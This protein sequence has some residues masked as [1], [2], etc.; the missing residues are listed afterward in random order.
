MYALE[1]PLRWLSASA[2]KK[3]P[4]KPYKIYGRRLRDIPC[5]PDHI[6]SN[7]EGWRL[8]Y[9]AR[10]DPR[11][12]WDEDIAPRMDPGYRPE[13]PSK[14]Q[15]ARN[16]F[17]KNCRMLGWVSRGGNHKAIRAD[18]LN[19]LHSRNISFKNN[20]T[21]GLSWGVVD[22][23]AGEGGGRIA[24]KDSLMQPWS[25]EDPPTCISKNKVFPPP[26]V[27]EVLYLAQPITNFTPMSRHAGCDGRDAES[28]SAGRKRKAPDDAEDL[29]EN[30]DQQEVDLMARN[31]CDS[32]NDNLRAI[33]RK[34][35]KKEQEQ[36]DD[37][38]ASQD[39]RPSR[40]GIAGTTSPNPLYARRRR[41]R[42]SRIPSREPIM[43]DTAGES[44]NQG[45][46][47][48]SLAD[49]LS[50][51]GWYDNTGYYADIHDNGVGEL[52]AS[53][54]IHLAE[55]P[56]RQPTARAKPTSNMAN[57]DDE[58]GKIGHSLLLPS[59]CF[60]DCFVG[61]RDPDFAS[62]DVEI[63]PSAE[64]DGE[65]ECWGSYFRRRT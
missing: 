8:E 63:S 13:H 3:P 40:Y 27:Q 44:I 32:I 26:P 12:R 14:I 64:L 37:E 31:D 17:R 10:L 55:D 35:K 28:S 48:P 23:A 24:V 6:S 5:L 52:P 41:R 42:S 51:G 43:R 33:S 16:R 59:L 21:R 50:Q 30:E 18:I 11:V 2:L 54:N 60:V 9:W 15:M 65:A 49:V 56:H 38:N 61:D 19:E 29:Q 47:D 20:T 36:T 45:E 53:N 7:L 1:R 62:Q 25:V 22:P 4:L 57:L 58:A 39:G 46:L 34:R